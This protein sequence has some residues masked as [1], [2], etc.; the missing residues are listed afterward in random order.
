MVHIPFDF[1]SVTVFY[2]QYIIMCSSGMQ[3]GDFRDVYVCRSSLMKEGVGG[4]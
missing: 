2:V 1:S 4:G 3:N